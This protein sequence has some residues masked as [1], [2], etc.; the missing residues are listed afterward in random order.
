MRILGIIPARGGSKGIPK[1]NIKLLNGKPLLAYT[2]EVALRS[3]LLSEVIVSTDDD[4]I[5]SVAKKL[6]VK[7]PFKRPVELARDDTPTIEVIFHA[8]KWY[9]DQN[10]NF[11]AVCLLQVTYPFRTLT[12]LNEA[13]QK[14]S[15]SDCDSLISVQKVP[16]IYNPHW[17]F[18]ANNNGNLYLA[19]GES[20]IISRRQEL[21]DAYHRDGSIY[22]TSTK[23]LMEKHSLYGRAIGF[24][25]SPIEGY[26]NIDTI[27]D[28]KKAEHIVK[29][30]TKD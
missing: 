7:V 27:E 9:E 10:I 25:E 5:M 12:F 26:V 24:I 2:A 11:D 13:I 23:T 6:G 29:T 15:S 3:R 28:W 18:E 8:L 16:H 14:F 20:E 30:F 22:L 1:K 4:D 21:P 17:V 19:T